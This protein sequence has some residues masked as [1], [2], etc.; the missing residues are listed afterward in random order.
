MTVQVSGEPLLSE[1]GLD[2]VA[3]ELYRL[4]L[5]G[6]DT[7]LAQCAA[8]LGRPPETVRAALHRLAACQLVHT[9]GPDDSVPRLVDPPIALGAV[10]AARQAEL[11][12]HRAAVDGLQAAASALLTRH[13]GQL[14]EIEVAYLATLG[15][16][17]IR[18]RIVQCADSAR[19]Q[20]LVLVPGDEDTDTRW[21]SLAA[22]QHHLVERGVRCR[23]VYGEAIRNSPSGFEHARALAAAGVELRT[24]ATVPPAMVVVDRRRAVLPCSQ[25][26]PRLGVIQVGIPGLAHVLHDMAADLWG[27]G[28]PFT[29]R[30]ARDHRG[31]TAQQSELLRLLAEGLTDEA[32]ARK[33]GVSVRTANRLTSALMERLGAGSRFEAGARAQQL[34]WLS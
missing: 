4:L 15:E 14:G 21:E 3:Q 32:A 24:S 18:A 2:P 28:T 34:G 33:L 26:R 31:L 30:P 16:E 13:R 1:L 23:A 5:E 6:Q 9:P 20:A 8:L 27:R 22:I 10:I 29:P 7:G 12:A 11:A 17:G 25:A 19:E